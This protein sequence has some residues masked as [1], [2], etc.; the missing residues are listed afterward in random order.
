[1]GI[2]AVAVEPDPV[3]IKNDVTIRAT[4][5]AYGFVGATVPVR[6]SFDVGQGFEEVKVVQATLG[7]L[8]GNEISVT[9]KAPGNPGEVKVKVEIPV[10]KVPG[11]VAPQNNTKITLFT[12]TKEGV[13]VLVVDRL[14]P[15]NTRFL[16]ALRAD[17]RLDVYLAVRQTDAPPEPGETDDFDFENRAYDVIVLGN[18][19]AN[20]LKAIHPKLPEQIRDLVLK[21]GVGLLVLGGEASFAGTPGRPLADGW[22]GSA[23]E[24]ILPVSLSTFPPGSSILNNDR[25]LFQTVPTPEGLDSYFMKVGDT[26]QQTKDLWDKLNAARSFSRM[27]AISRMGTPLPTATVYAVAADDREAIPA[28]TRATDRTAPLLVAHAVGD[29]Q[30]GR[31][32]A[33]AGADSYLWEVMGLKEGKQGVLL[34]HRFWKQVVLWLAHQELDEGNAYAR[35]KFRDLLVRN[36]QTVRVG[37]RQPGGADALEPK[38]EVKVLAPGEPETQAKS[39]PV[40]PDPEGGAKFVYDPPLPGEYVVKL[41]ATGKDAKGNEV[42]GEATARFFASPEV[43]EEMLRTAAD[44]DFLAKLAG[45]GGGKSLRLEDLPNILRDLKAQ[46]IDTAKP[47]PRYYPDWRRDHSKAFLPSWLA[48]F[49]VLLGTEWALRRSWGMV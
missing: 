30:R 10:E 47:K 9:V 25:A 48:F 8:T 42:K 12:T 21:K 20:Q 5:H 45:A 38:F 17:K 28:G 7:K 33:F 1:V 36:T 6:V 40:V 34:H 43:S 31:V 27:N 16:D 14:R 23:L 29:N 41:T 32:M 4:V 22:K 3:P 15:E 13:R 2:T 19:S 24:S 35:P 11:D 46:P 44:Y 37:L 49:V 26:P 39:P 18:V